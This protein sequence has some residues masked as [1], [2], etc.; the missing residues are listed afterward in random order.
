MARRQRN[1]LTAE[2]MRQQPIELVFLA[3][4]NATNKYL[5]NALAYLSWPRGWV[6]HARYQMKWLD[7]GV[8]RDLPPRSEILAGSK[9]KLVGKR[10]LTGYLFQERMPAESWKQI[11]LYPLRYGTIRQA[12]RVG[13]T[14]SDVAHFYFELEGFYVPEESG[15]YLDPLTVLGANTHVKA[16]QFAVNASSPLTDE[17]TA[18]ARLEGIASN[19]LVY[20]PDP[21]NPTIA[22]RCY[23]FICRIRG[24][25]PARKPAKINAPRFDP[26]TRT[27]RY[28]VR[29]G[30]ELI[31]DINFYV[32]SWCTAPLQDSKLILTQDEKAFSTMAHRTLPVASRYDEQAWLIVAA[33][34][35]RSLLRDVALETDLRVP[36]GLEP[37]NLDLT[38]P[39]LIKPSRWRRVSSVVLDMVAAA[40]L[41]LGTGALALSAKPP[42]WVHAEWLLPAVIVGYALWFVVSLV[43]RLWKP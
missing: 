27:S 28:V 17:S 25:H 3:S 1:Q 24:L 22:I 6:A 11:A 31:L 29:E 23:P 21:S 20:H 5:A 40:G 15:P 37:I 12:Y 4:S 32:P 33:A 34:T 13:R 41:A 43:V 9:S 39:V 26:A 8:A 16:I 2:D 18:Q 19:H 10:I 7:A 30:Q 35:Q 14:A 38:L 42:S 36:D